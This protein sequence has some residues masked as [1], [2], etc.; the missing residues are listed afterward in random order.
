[1]VGTSA[2]L[3]LVFAV[4]WRLAQ[5][6]SRQQQLQLQVAEK[7]AELQRQADYL[8]A[9]DMERSELLAK[10]K[11]QAQEFEQQAYLD[12][13]TGLANRRAFDEAL[14]RECARARRSNSA[15]SLALMDIDHFKL[16]NDTY[17]H[18]VGDEILKQVAK[19]ISVHCREDDTV[20]RW[21]G[22]EFAIL[23]PNT[24][25]LMAREICER[26]RKAV[27]QIDCSTLAPGLKLTISMGIAEFAGEDKHEKLLSRSDSALY[28]AKQ[29][30]RNR[31]DIAIPL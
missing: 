22:E 13:L 20:A 26:V 31:V 5:L 28:K 1:M 23:L 30:G 21:G 7:T 25:A 9:A 3:L 19:V 6:K 24:T 29:S 15:L 16:V 10:L 14:T 17:S 8:T 27:M 11:V 2:S 18:S 12:A 4:R